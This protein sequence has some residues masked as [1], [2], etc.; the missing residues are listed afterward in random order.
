MAEKVW[1]IHRLSAAGLFELDTEEMWRGILKNM[2]GQ[3][4]VLSNYPIDP[5]LN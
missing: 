5:R 1:I 4:K 2:G 3:Y